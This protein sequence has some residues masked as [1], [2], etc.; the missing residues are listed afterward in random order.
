MKNIGDIF[1]QSKT[2]E[3]L[4]RREKREEKLFSAWKE[5]MGA[6]CCSHTKKLTLKNGRLYVH[7]DSQVWKQELLMMEL[8]KKTEQ[9][10]DVTGY[11]IA[12][13]CL[14]TGGW[15]NT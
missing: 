11:K 12:K 1:K 15:H 6:E 7:L 3:K 4:S 2:K 10:A 9:I 13:I 14:R 5:I 8:D